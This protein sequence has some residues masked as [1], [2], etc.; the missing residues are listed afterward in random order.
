MHIGGKTK[1]NPL[2]SFYIYFFG[3]L[4]WLVCIIFAICYDAEKEKNEE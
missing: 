2:T 4:F 1:M 3:F